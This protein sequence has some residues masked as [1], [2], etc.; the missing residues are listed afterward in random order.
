MY[1]LIIVALVILSILLVGLV[2]LQ[3]GKQSGLQGMANTGAAQQLL[4]TR[5]SADVLEKATWSVILLIVLL[6]IFSALAQTGGTTEV[7]KPTATPTT[8]P[9]APAQKAPAAPAPATKP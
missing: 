3:P 2:L 5:Q 6:S 4:G 8:A 7:I 1:T 9:A